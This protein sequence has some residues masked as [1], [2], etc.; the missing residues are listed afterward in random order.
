MLLFTSLCQVFFI[1]EKIVK[2][3]SFLTAG[4]L[5][6]GMSSVAVKAEDVK[7]LTPLQKKQFEKVV[8]DYLVENPEVLIEASQVLQKRQQDAMQKDSKT[9]IAQHAAE[10]VVG[11]LS[12]AGNKDGNV[13]LV[14][15]FDYQCIHCKKMETVVDTLI[16]KN[17]DLRVV[18]KE[19]PIFGKDSEIAS[20]VAMAAAMQGKYLVLQNALFKAD[21][22]LNEKRIMDIAKAAGLD[23]NKLQADMQSQKI[24]DALKE[25]RALAEKIRIMGTPAFVVLS[26]PNGKLKP[27]SE[28][29]FIPGAAS[30][31]SLQKLINKAK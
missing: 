14:E 29:A 23:M 21:G 7:D 30:E 27:N 12:V 1:W 20:K 28:A 9:A 25:N 19:F 18:Y 16:T 22:R 11:D 5:V 26:T 6:F 4:A 13:T 31:S 8:H 2:L 17:K 3:T 10:L 15:F 24:A